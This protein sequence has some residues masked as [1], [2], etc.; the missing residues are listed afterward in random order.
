MKLKFKKGQTIIY[1]FHGVGVVRSVERKMITGK[2]VM[3][4]VLDFRDGDLTVMVPVDKGEEMGM[5]KVISQKE[6]PKIYKILRKKVIEEEPDWKVR[7]NIYLEKLKSG[8]I[9][10]AAEVARNLSRRAPEGELSMSEKRLLESSIA[11][12]VNEIA[13]AKRTTPEKTKL[14]LD[15]MLIKKRSKK[16]EKDES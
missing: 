12:L 13:T 2:R 7:Y 3:Y 4:Y 6:L 16:D 1:P 10:E 8:S 5:R 11:L 9:Q 14:E 15:K